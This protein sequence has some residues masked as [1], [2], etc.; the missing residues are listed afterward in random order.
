[1]DII[2]KAWEY[3]SSRTD[4]FWK[5][6]GEH[7][8]LSFGAL[9]IAILICLP[10]GIFSSRFGRRAQIL[11]NIF[12]ILRVIPSL[13]ILIAL[14]PVLGVG[15]TPALVALTLLACP[16]ILINTDAGMRE[17]PPATLENARAMGMTTWEV[18]WQV[19]IPL[20]LPVILGGLRTAAIEVIASATLATYIGA[21]G[22]GDFIAQGLAGND[23]RVLLVGAIPV[24]LLAMLVELGLARLQRAVSPRRNSQFKTA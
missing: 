24:A 16:P 12:G 13:A 7:L 8:Q 3:G 1:M 22:F 18:L 20:A 11:I 23:G 6:F 17:V 5:H 21:G 10:L 19:Q 14:L 9:L 15:F 4:E 2:F